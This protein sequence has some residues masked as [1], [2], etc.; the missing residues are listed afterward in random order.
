MRLITRIYSC[1]PART[2]RCAGEFA[3]REL[4]RLALIS[5]LGHRRFVHLIGR[6]PSFARL[7]QPIHALLHSVVRPSIAERRR[8]RWV[9]QRCDFACKVL[10]ADGKGKEQGYEE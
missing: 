3:R 8:L 2:E 6:L 1:A 9:D 5:R 10:R 7:G 4:R